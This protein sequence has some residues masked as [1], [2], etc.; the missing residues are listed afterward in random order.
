M[1]IRARDDA[2]GPDRWQASRAALSF[3]TI[4]VAGTT[5]SCRRSGRSASGRPGPRGGSRR[6]RRAR[7]R[8]PPARV[9]RI[10]VAGVGI[11]DDRHVD[12]I[13]HRRQ[14]VDNASRGSG[15]GRGRRPSARSPRR[16][17]RPRGSL[18]ARRAA[19]KAHH[20]RRAPRR[21]GPRQTGSSI[22]SQRPRS[23]SPS[24]ASGTMSTSG[25]GHEESGGSAMRRGVLAALAILF[26]TLSAFA[27]D[28]P[29]KQD[30]PTK[31]VRII[32][33]FGPGATPDMV[34]RLIADHLQQTLGQPFMSRTSPAPAAIPAPTRSPRPSRTATPSASASAGRSRSTRC[35]SP[36]CP[37][38][39]KR[40]SR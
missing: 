39:R 22:L 10:A 1:R 21:C 35:C 33:P 28:L 25:R 24:P 32:V 15:R 13:D 23:L 4:S 11:G 27:Q 8:A 5:D 17:H 29:A 9:E 2:R 3:C 26:G 7:R 30:W 31:R 20:R 14:P 34:A 38:I 16:W 37:T 36:R 40:T 12:D 6:R 19:P 18:L